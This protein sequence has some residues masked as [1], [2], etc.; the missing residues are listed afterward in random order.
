MLDFHTLPMRPVRRFATASPVNSLPSSP[1]Y[2]PIIHSPPFV[3]VFVFRIVAVITWRPFPDRL[4]TTSAPP[5][6]LRPRAQLVNQRRVAAAPTAIF[7]FLKD[8]QDDV[9]PPLL[10][11]GGHQLDLVLHERENA[12]L[13]A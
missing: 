4:L 10:G 6:Q 7:W 2:V 5:V 12:D 13:I 8:V 11:K 9:S 1:P 3:L